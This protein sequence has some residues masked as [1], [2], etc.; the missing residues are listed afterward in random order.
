M[1]TTSAAEDE[2]VANGSPA[3]EKRNGTDDTK[4]TRESNGTNV[5]EAAVDE[6]TQLN[7]AAGTV[8]TEPTATIEQSVIIPTGT[9]QWSFGH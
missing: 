4:K 9:D 6:S 8:M 5:R 1:G 2:D 7:K 3:A